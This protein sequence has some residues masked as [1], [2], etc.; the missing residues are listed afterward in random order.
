MARLGL[1]LLR[2]KI[3]GHAWLEQVWE[4][5]WCGIALTAI[6]AAGC[7][8]CVLWVP[9]PGVSVAIMGLAAALMAARTKATGAEKA[10]WMLI[11]STLLVTEV[12]AIHKDRELHDE[13]IALLF[14]QGENIKGQAETKFGELGG[15]L[16]GEIDTGK[17]ILDKTNSVM[18]LS[19]QK[20]A[21]YYGRR[22]VRCCDPTGV[23]RTGSD[24]VDD[25][26]LREA[27]A[28]GSYGY[29]SRPRIVGF[30]S[31]SVQYVPS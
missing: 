14:K 11:I 27:D 30:S 13:Q 10:A 2:W 3:E 21:K 20:P 16:E 29:Y 22:F 23:E 17:A 8:S 26:Q 12:L 25:L 4:N 15:K 5:R 24:S 1:A 7:L 28:R 31:Q 19:E 6:G 9:A 18:K